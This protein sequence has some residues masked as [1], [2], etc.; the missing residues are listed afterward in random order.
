MSEYRYLGK[1]VP[2]EEA[3]EKLRS[4]VEPVKDVVELAVW[5]AIGHVLAEPVTAPYDFPPRPR[6]AY[7]GYAVF[8]GDTPGRLR[9][10][11][12]AP[13]G[14]VDLGLRIGRGEAVYVSTGAYLPDGADV[15]VPEEAV[16][17]EG[18]YIIVDRRFESGKNLDPAGAYVKKGQVLLD[19]GYVVTVSD[20]VALL[21]V[22]VTSVKVYRKLR[23]GIIATG[24]EL[25]KPSN[26]Q[27]T[28]NKILQGYV[29][30]TTTSLIK[31]ALEALTPWTTIVDY[32][33]LPDD[34][35]T[36]AWR[37]ERML[38]HADLVLLTG[39]TGPSEVDNFYQ[40]LGHL[41]AEIVFRGLAMRG[42]RPTS[43]MLVDGK[44]VIGLSGHPVSA[45]HGF[46][47]VVE[48]LL[49]HMASVRRTPSKPLIYAR[50]ASGYQTPF[51]R[52][53][54]VR[55]WLSNGEFW[56][57]PLPKPQQLSSNIASITMADGYAIV[58]AGEYRRGERIPVLL[59]REPSRE[60][61][62]G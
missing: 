40:L 46:I 24:G 54:R 35:D 19:R 5:D 17:R 6:A 25:F 2:P 23:I 30:E 20:V 45:L 14:K 50:W 7:D 34:V 22:A 55:V 42:G 36:I 11:A 16:K 51:P 53:V 9:I 32:D 60:H 8:S 33:L 3:A 61:I 43:A 31:W 1:L 26:P 10:I 37:I 49:R 48:P 4:L 18:D 58:D 52:L 41:R 21:D 27:I 38:D 13:L 15:V 39:G 28:A 44:P 57:E 59:Y 47:R 62:S 29:A 12:E 56:A